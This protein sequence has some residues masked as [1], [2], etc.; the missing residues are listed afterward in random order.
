MKRLFSLMLIAPV[1][2]YQILISPLFPPSCRFYPTCSTYTIEALQKHGPFRGTWLGLRRIFRC[3]PWHPGGYDPGPIRFISET[4]IMDR[5]TV[6]GFVLIA[7]IFIVWM[8]YMA[9]QPQD[10]VPP[11]AAT[12]QQEARKDTSVQPPPASDQPVDT[13]ALSKPQQ[14]FGLW[15]AEAAEGDKRSIVVETEK[16]IAEFSTHGGSIAR[17]TLKDFKTWDGRPLQLI[18]WKRTSDFNLVFSSADGRYIDT[19][20]LYFQIRTEEGKSRYTLS[21]K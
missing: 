4:T 15:F 6:I 16:Y 11:P 8:F 10:V 5:Q 2:L 14:Q 7:V 17:W 1:R 21:G 20:D 12:E 18:D 19:K 3:H 13:L 9:P